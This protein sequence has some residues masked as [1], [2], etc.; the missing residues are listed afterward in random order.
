[1]VPSG[2]LTMS[3]VDVQTHIQALVKNVLYYQQ[4]NQHAGKRASKP[5][6]TLSRDY[7]TGSRRIVS[8]LARQ[9]DIPIYDKQIL[10]AI[11]KQAH[12]SVELMAEL[13]EK[14][15]HYK[16]DWVVSLLTGQNAS[17]DGYRHHLVNVVLGICYSGGI[18]IGRGA[19]VILAE[20]EVFRVRLVGS[21]K[22]C[23]ARVAAEEKLNPSAAIQK[24]QAINHERGEFLWETF[25]QRLNEPTLFDLVINTDRVADSE[26]VVDIILRTMQ[27]IGY[28]W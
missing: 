27:H 21:L 16:S 20:R 28:Q 15:S 3:D 1:M 5:T 8:A 4:Q 14:V 18:I 26:A 25:R 12:V 17:L 24:V 6:I 19:H 10:D 2:R 22:S 23:A 7:G 13:D 11:A 9:L